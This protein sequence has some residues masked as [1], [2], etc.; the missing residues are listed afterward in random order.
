LSPNGRDAFAIHSGGFGVFIGGLHPSTTPTMPPSGNGTRETLSQQLHGLAGRTPVQGWTLGELM[1]A[2]GAR[3]SGLLVIVC[4][5]PF[6]A[7]VTIPGLSTPFGLVI[8][9]LSLR[10]ALG[11]PPWL[12]RRL[13]QVALPPK[14]LAKILEAGSRVIA[15]IERR[16]R[17]RWLFLVMPRW[18]LRVHAIAIM[19]SAM[20]LMLPL[21][22]IP[23]F[24]NTLPALVIVVM[25]M[26]TLE[27]DGAGIVAGY[28]IFVGMIVYFVLW[29]GVLAEG[30]MRIAERFGFWGS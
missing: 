7:P 17:A 4:A 11:R 30:F 26:S 27:R 15:W 25:A 3:A 18:K 19:L 16:M 12:P 2:L 6:C 29:A 10:Y 9:V 22:P 1:D 13:R 8:F 20:I 14:G 24:T 21:P 23:P 5:L 28:G